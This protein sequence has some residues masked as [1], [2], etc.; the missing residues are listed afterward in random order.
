MEFDVHITEAHVTL[1]PK[2]KSALGRLFAKTRSLTAADI[3]DSRLSLALGDL[4]VLNE[5][6]SGSAVVLEDRIVLNH[7]AVARVD[8]RDGPCSWPSALARSDP[9]D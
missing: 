2:A 6:S 9:R 8:R 5:E 3:G 4:A 1:S 7:D